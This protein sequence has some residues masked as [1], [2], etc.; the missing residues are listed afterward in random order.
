[1]LFQKLN[2]GRDH[3]LFI[4]R[5]LAPGVE[6][7]GVFDL[8]FHLGNITYKEYI[9]NGKLSSREAQTRPGFINRTDFVIHPPRAETEFA[10]YIFGEIS[11]HS[12][13]LFRPG[14]PQRGLLG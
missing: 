14:D 9:V 3:N 10:D 7:I 5:Q 8:L 12:R 2:L 11:G 1:M 6:F 13:S 4:F